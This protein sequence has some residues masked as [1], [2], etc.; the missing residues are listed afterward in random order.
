LKQQDR[1]L[2]FAKLESVGPPTVCTFADSTCRKS[3]AEVD[4]TAFQTSATLG[5]GRPRTHAEIAAREEHTEVKKA[6][7]GGLRHSRRGVGT[8][9]VDEDSEEE[10]AFERLLDEN[11]HL[12]SNITSSPLGLAK[13]TVPNVMEAGTS[14]T[15]PQLAFAAPVMPA[16]GSALRRNADGSIITP[17]VMHRKPKGKKV[18]NR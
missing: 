9:D 4:P 10:R 13:G 17:L 15:A 1:V 18:S 12:P 14:I 3:Q 16:V 11:A 6:L 8:M 2:I 7:H 5:S